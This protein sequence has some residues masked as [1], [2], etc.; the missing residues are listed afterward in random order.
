MGFFLIQNLQ[1]GQAKIYLRE[2]S[3]AAN[4]MNTW[5]TTLSKS[6]KSPGSTKYAKSKSEQSIIYF[7]NHMFIMSDFLKE[8]FARGDAKKD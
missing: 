2:K 3:R 5:R 8:S 6:Y 7:T 1:R 4:L